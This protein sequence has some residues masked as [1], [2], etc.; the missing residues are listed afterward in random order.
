MRFCFEDVPRRSVSRRTQIRESSTSG[1]NS[2]NNV[3]FSISN[4]VVSSISDETKHIHGES[5]S[6]R[7][8]AQRHAVSRKG[9]EAIPSRNARSD[10]PLGDNSPVLIRSYG[11]KASCRT[12]S[13]T[14]GICC[15][16][17]AFLAAKTF[18]TSDPTHMARMDPSKAHQV[19]SA[20]RRAA[21]MS[22]EVCLRRCVSQ[23]N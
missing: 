17:V 2:M 15:R 18:L 10:R 5:E 22:G 3:H 13:S 9:S 14:S 11:V 1:R 6:R 20:A 23:E 21:G 12:L 4:H 8:P 7:H 19:S 16:V